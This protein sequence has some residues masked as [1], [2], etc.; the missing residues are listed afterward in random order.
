MAS[1]VDAGA[2]DG[3]WVV[4]SGD[5]GGMGDD[6]GAFGCGADKNARDAVFAFSLAA[7][8]DVRI[9]TEGSSFDTVIGVFDASDDSL[10]GCDDDSGAFTTSDLT[11]SLP[12]GSYYIVLAGDKSNDR[13]AYTLSLAD[14]GASN[15]ITCD[16]DSGGSGTSEITASLVPGDYHVV[17][18]GKGDAEAGAYSLRITDRDYWSVDHRLE[19]DDDSGPL[20]ASQ[21]ERSLDPGTYYVVVKG[22][23]S[24]AYGSQPLRVR[25]IDSPDATSHQLSCDDD[26]GTSTGSRLELDLDAGTYWAVLKGKGGGEGNYALELRDVGPSGLGTRLACDDD[27]AGSGDSSIEQDLAAGSY[28]LYVKGDS[29]GDQGAYDL[30]I[31]DVTHEGV[32]RIACDQDS[33]AG[34]ASVITER[35]TAGTYYAVLKGDDAASS[36]AY[37]LSLRD[38]A[39]LKR[40]NYLCTDAESAS[41]TLAAGA[42]DLVLKGEDGAEEGSYVLSVGDGT[43]GSASFMPPQWST[44]LDALND[45][46]MRVITV[47]NC[48]DNGSHG[49]GR[50]CDDARSQAVEMANATDALGAD[51]SPLVIDIDSNGAGLEN[52]VI[53]QLQ[54]LSGHLEMDVSVRVVFDPDANPGFDLE[55]SAIDRPGDGCD[56]LIGLEHQNCRPGATPTFHLDFTN[57]LDNPVPLNPDDPLGGYNFRAELIA[58]GKY[59]IDAVPIYIIPEDVDGSAEPPAPLIQP[60][61]TYWQDLSSPGCMGTTRPTWRDLFYTADI[62]DGTSLSF[63]VCTAEQVA[64]LEMCTTDL[65]ATV[66]GSGTCTMDAECGSGFCAPNGV[67]QLVTA[68]ACVMDSQCAEGAS[69][70]TDLGACVYTSQPVFVGTV[71]GTN[72]TDLS[73]YLRMYID[74]TANVAMNVGPTLYD[75]ALTYECRS[76]D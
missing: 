3:R 5:T 14:T 55:I 49:D 22:D 47:L 38:A 69:C 6:Y 2:L 16:D 65:V 19:C 56:G 43:T 18:K 12:I 75:W 67:C 44:T 52:A 36:G 45:R 58:D 53:G 35:L 74:M 73:R 64:Q 61:G 32:D 7:A 10:L 48:H 31:T 21:I 68:G 57:P 24:T 8:T 29:S 59:F 66:Q 39:T 23:Q 46:E 4:Y 72:N 11:L 26:S 28:F 25:D 76:V 1:A 33:G 51:L 70:D 40:S 37:S 50:D 30:N 9:Q 13:G 34:D 71:F 17:V 41:A 60:T 54:A 42:Y 27:S 20:W 62:P 15:V 63:R